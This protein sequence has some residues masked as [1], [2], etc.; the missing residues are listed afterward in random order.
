MQVYNPEPVPVPSS[1][2]PVPQPWFADPI[3]IIRPVPAMQ[4]CSKCSCVGSDATIKTLIYKKRLCQYI[5]L[6]FRDRFTV[7][8]LLENGTWLVSMDRAHQAHTTPTKPLL[9]LLNSLFLW[10]TASISTSCAII[11]YLRSPVSFPS[12]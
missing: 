1:N 2:F 7:L 3:P 12:F 6:S 11:S 4:L 5:S 10:E 9:T 8:V